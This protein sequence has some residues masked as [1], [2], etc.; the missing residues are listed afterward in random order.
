MND[1]QKSA[2]DQEELIPGTSRRPLFIVV[3]SVLLF[4]EAALMVGV[5][6][7]LLFELLTDTASSITSALAIFVMAIIGVVWVI[8][9]AIAVTRMRP[10]GRG[11]V[12]T[13]QIVQLA[14]AI[15]SFQGSEPK[16]GL[17]WALLVPSIIGILLVF[18][19]SVVSATQS[20]K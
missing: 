20:R 11:A 12:I 16:T 10:W 19:P 5:V 6:A 2:D 15:G 9:A 4:A 17:G 1:G 13:W 14:V 7:W 3:L 18:T 8:A